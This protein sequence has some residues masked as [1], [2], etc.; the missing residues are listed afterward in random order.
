[1]TVQAALFLYCSQNNLYE[2]TQ[3]RSRRSVP[4]ISALFYYLTASNAA[5][6]AAIRSFTFSVPMDRRIVFGLMP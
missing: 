5:S 1:M 6:S 2:T 4:C 3:G